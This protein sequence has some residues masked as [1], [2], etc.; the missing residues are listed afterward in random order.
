M[1]CYFMNMLALKDWIRASRLTSQSYILLPL[2]LGQAVA[3]YQTGSLSVP[4]LLITHLFGLFIQ[5]FIIYAND[6]ADIETD[7]D[8]STYTVFTGGSRVLVEGAISKRSMGKA[9]VLMVALNI[10]LGLILT[11]VFHRTLSL[12]FIGVALGL[13][14]AYSYRPIILSYRGGG[15]LLQLIGVGILLP[16][17]SFYLQRG[18]VLLFPMEVVIILL[19]IQLSCALSTT[20]PDYPSDRRHNKRTLAVLLSPVAVKVLIIALNI[21]TLFL[22]VTLGSPS[23][24]VSLAISSLP[25]VLTLAM[26]SLLRHADAGNPRLFYFVLFNIASVLVFVAGLSL[27]Y[28]TAGTH[29][30]IK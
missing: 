13:L 10:S 2:L 26:I 12:V 3:Y 24:G 6:Y 14:W 17:F 30:I 8:N 4:I 22:L 18:S 21:A 15:E 1:V 29:Y 20:L 19:P 5:L 27:Y 23:M 16:L 25:I 9:I 7:K 11:L 28:L